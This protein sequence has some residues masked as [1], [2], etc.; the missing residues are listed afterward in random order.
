ME[1]GL[2]R[3]A[4]EVVPMPQ[5]PDVYRNVLRNAVVRVK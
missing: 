3:E 4:V 5:I 2:L 1:A